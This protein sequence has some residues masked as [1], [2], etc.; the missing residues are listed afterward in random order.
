MIIR[1]QI[2]WVCVNDLEFFLAEGNSSQDLDVYFEMAGKF[3]F[4]NNNLN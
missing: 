3:E 1:V 2:D 4:Q